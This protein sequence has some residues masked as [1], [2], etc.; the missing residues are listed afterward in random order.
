MTTP[1]NRPHRGT[2]RSAK[3]WTGASIEQGLDARN[4][5]FGKDAR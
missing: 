3:D 5:G 2:R 4:G 1:R